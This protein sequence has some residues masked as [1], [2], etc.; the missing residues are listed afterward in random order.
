V[1]RIRR[2]RDV[3]LKCT[4]RVADDPREVKMVSANESIADDTKN[5]LV[6]MQQYN[7]THTHTHTTHAHT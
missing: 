2:T 4:G 6:Q 3:I 1:K 5:T 7:C